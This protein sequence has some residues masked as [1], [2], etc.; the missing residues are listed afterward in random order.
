MQSAKE[1]MHLYLAECIVEEKHLQASHAAFR[2]KF[3]TND[4]IWSSRPGALE[5]LQSEKVESILDSE[6]TEVI[7]TRRLPDGP[8]SLYTLRYLLRVRNGDWM[9]CEVDVE[10]CSC[11]GK[12]GNAA[13]RH[14]HGTG[15]RNTNI[16]K[17]RTS[18]PDQ[19]VEAQKVTP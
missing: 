11:A 7:T 3:Y 12:P 18:A 4:C 15:W 5:L 14:C 13:C 8:E 1:F 9:I 17:I 10:C 19:K 2:R 6:E 16:L